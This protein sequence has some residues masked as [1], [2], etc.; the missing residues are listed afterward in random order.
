MNKKELI[1]TILVGT[2]I[3]ASGVALALR[4]NPAPQGLGDAGVTRMEGAATSGE[5]LVATTDTN[6]V[7]KNAGRQY[8]IVCKTNTQNNQS[9]IS[10]SINASASHGRG[11]VLDSRHPC[12]ESNDLD[13]FTGLL[14]AVASPSAASVSWMYY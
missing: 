10:F 8:L 5:T 6:L 1:V 7:A 2:L 14:E 13:L 11:V 9:Q 12:W 3:V 4:L